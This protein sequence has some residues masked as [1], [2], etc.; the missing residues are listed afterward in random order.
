MFSSLVV[1]R[2]R[3]PR[4][5]PPSCVTTD[6]VAAARVGHLLV[7]NQRRQ[8]RIVPAQ[9]EDLPFVL[10]VESAFRITGR[11]RSSWGSSIRGPCIS[12][13]TSK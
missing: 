3:T 9:D 5:R 7:R 10:K 13:T 12:V 6:D 2:P 1:S 11:E 8:G 4:W